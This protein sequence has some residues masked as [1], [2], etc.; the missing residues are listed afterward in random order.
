MLGAMGAASKLSRAG[1]WAVGLMS[2][3]AGEGATSGVEAQTQLP[4]LVVTTPS[5]VRRAPTGHRG[6]ADACPRL[7]GRH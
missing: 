6:S 7:F 5:P 2:A 1:A 3:I 4:E